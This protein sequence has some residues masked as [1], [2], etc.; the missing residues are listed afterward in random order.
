[1]DRE[2]K[3]QRKREAHRHVEEIEADTDRWEKR[4][5]DVIAKEKAFVEL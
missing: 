4:D 3:K 2:R 1:M 5:D